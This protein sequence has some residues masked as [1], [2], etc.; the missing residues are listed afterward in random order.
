MSTDM[1]FNSIFIFGVTEIGPRTSP[2]SGKN[3][4]FELWHLDSSF[5]LFQNLET[6]F[7]L[8]RSKVT[9]NPVCNPNRS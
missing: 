5:L 9:M 3:W 4:T 2:M 7:H 8:S 1:L 6:G